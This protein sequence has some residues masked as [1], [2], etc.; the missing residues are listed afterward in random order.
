MM[1][2]VLMMCGG[3]LVICFLPTYATIGAWAPF[4]PML[5]RLF[6]GSSVGGEYGTSATYMSEVALK[7]RWRLFRVVPVRDADRRAACRAA[8]VLNKLQLFS[9]PRS[10]KAWGWRILFF[11]GA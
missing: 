1:I 2:S 7:G 9:P 3:L 8:P 11:I 6:Q 4:L 5:A 10:W